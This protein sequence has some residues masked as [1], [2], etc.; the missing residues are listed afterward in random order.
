V[1]LQNYSEIPLLYNQGPFVFQTVQFKQCFIAVFNRSAKLG[2]GSTPELEITSQPF[3]LSRKHKCIVGCPDRSVPAI[4]H[5]FSETRVQW[6]IVL[7]TKEAALGDRGFNGYDAW[8]VV[9]N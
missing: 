7:K 6:P 1:I 4:L 8:G 3:Q 9:R 2:Y 5:S